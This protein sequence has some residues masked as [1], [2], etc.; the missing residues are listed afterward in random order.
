MDND[1]C[2]I[3]EKGLRPIKAKKYYYFTKPIS[4]KL[5]EFQISHNNFDVG[6]RGKWRKFNP[7]NPF[8]ESNEE[9]RENNLK[10]ESLDDLFE[11]EKSDPKIE[12]PKEEAPIL[13]LENNT[14]KEELFTKDL[15]D[16]LEAKFD[17]LFGP[18]NYNKDNKK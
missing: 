2:I 12:E 18:I 1:L 7:M 8:S 13:P 10:I 15:Q 9:E 11:D 14:K 4:R 17:E 6:S 5:K 3:F 16:E